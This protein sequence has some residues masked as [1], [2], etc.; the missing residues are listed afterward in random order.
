MPSCIGNSSKACRRIS[1]TDH[2]GVNNECR[3]VV[4]YLQMLQPRGFDDTLVMK[5]FWIHSRGA[6]LFTTRYINYEKRNTPTFLV[7]VWK[8]KPAQHPVRI[9]RWL[10]TKSQKEQARARIQNATR[11]FHLQAKTKNSCIR[12]HSEIPK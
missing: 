4:I 6:M 1:E 9:I 5:P 3:R 8:I 12:K 7:V 11:D 10:Y 2:S